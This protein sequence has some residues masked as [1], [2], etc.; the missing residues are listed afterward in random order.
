MREKM[1]VCTKEN[2]RTMRAPTTGIRL[3]KPNRM[4]KTS[5]FLET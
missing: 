4:G 1:A 3:E 5:Y 2:R